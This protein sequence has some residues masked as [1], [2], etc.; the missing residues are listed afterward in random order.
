P[1]FLFPVWPSRLDSDLGRR[2]RP[3]KSYQ[4]QRPATPIRFDSPSA[5]TRGS[6]VLLTMEGDDPRVD[7]IQPAASHATSV[8]VVRRVCLWF[9]PFRL[10]TS[11]GIRY[12]E[13][14]LWQLVVRPVGRAMALP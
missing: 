10:E 8:A 4:D 12:D 11:L 9:P 6:S 5:G 7:S 2:L 3:V 14:V 13:S 1:L